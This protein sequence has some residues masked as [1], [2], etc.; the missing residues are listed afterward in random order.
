M[1]YT[2]RKA[3]CDRSRASS[4]SRRS[5]HA[6]RYARPWWRATS[7]SKAASSPAAT[8]RVGGLQPDA[9]AH[10]MAIEAR[11]PGLAGGAHGGIEDGGAG[12]ARADGIERGLQSRVDRLEHPLLAVGGLAHHRHAGDVGVI[13]LHA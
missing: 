4:A 2:R 1:R 10:V 6:R 11:E 8:R 13:A 12:D 9:V 3:S 7:R 5:D